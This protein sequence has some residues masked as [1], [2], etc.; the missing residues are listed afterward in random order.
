M[1]FAAAGLRDSW[2]RREYNKRR[3]ERLCK[4][5]TTNEREEWIY[6]SMGAP[7][8][9]PA[10]TIALIEKRQAAGNVQEASPALYETIIKERFSDG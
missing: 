3:H 8:R 9:W 4:Y 7:K 1:V 2:E 10:R 5:A 6:R